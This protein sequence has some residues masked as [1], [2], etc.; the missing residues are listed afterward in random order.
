[1]GSVAATSGDSSIAQTFTIP[2]GATTLAFWYLVHCPDTVTHDW[3]TATLR[4]NTTSTTV[5]LLPRTCSNT[6]SWVQVS[7]SVSGLVGHSVTLTLTNHDDNNPLDATYTLYDDVSVTGAASPVG[8][9]NPSLLVPLLG[10]FLI[11]FASVRRRAIAL[12]GLRRAT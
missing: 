2:S 12:F 5:T 10:L 3:A 6:G 1:M 8:G 4:D 9:A 7:T 11:P